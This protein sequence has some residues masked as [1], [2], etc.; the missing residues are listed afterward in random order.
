MNTRLT[1]NSSSCV[2]LLTHRHVVPHACS[3]VSIHPY[4]TLTSCSQHILV[5]IHTVMSSSDMLTHIYTQHACICSHDHT[6]MITYAHACSHMI[7]TCTHTCSH[8][9]MHD[10]TPTTCLHTCSYPPTHT[11]FR[12]RQ[13]ESAGPLGGQECADLGKLQPQTPMLGAKSPCIACGYGLGH[14]A[15]SQRL[16]TDCP[17]SQ[18]GEPSDA[19][20]CHLYTVTITQ[21]GGIQEGK[22]APRSR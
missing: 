8:T 15:L 20:N 10:H 12:K 16:S 14:L 17:T 5:P 19:G 22:K 11:C 2:C 13:L 3:C 21:A 18:Q 6:S 7:H 9:H 1:I 4:Y